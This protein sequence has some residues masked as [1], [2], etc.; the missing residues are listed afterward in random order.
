MTHYG[1][2]MKA[3]L[4]IEE[5]WIPVHHVALHRVADLEL[6]RDQFAVAVHKEFLHPGVGLLD[7]VGT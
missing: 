6:V 1:D 4:P 3:G 5:Y 2:T 7:V